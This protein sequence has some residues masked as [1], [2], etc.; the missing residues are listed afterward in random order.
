[1]LPKGEGH[2]L[3]GGG[4]FEAEQFAARGDIPHG[5][6]ARSACGEEDGG[7]GGVPGERAGESA[8]APE[9]PDGWIAQQSLGRLLFRQQRFDEAEPHFARV[10][11]AQE[12]VLAE[13]D[14][15]LADTRAW[16]E[17]TQRGLDARR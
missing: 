13:D 12:S 7:V 8:L 17:R 1:M 15:E 2:G 16:L 3:P 6:D 4:I 10:L 14:A 9:H 11:E 5:D